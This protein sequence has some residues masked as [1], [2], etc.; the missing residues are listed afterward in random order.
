[1]E[2]TAANLTVEMARKDAVAQWNLELQERMLRGELTQAQALYFVHPE[3]VTRAPAAPG[4]ENS[5]ACILLATGCVCCGRPLVDAKSV[6]CAVGPYCRKR[7]GFNI[8]VSEAAR[9]EANGLVYRLAALL[10]R[11]VEVT[12]E[13]LAG[14]QRLVELGFVV[15]AGKIADRLG[16]LE[17]K[18][19]DGNRLV[20]QAPYSETA[21]AVLRT[22]PGRRWEG[23]AVG[24]SFPVG[25][26][27][28][29]WRA[30]GQAYPGLL[31]VGPTGRISLL[32]E[33]V[34]G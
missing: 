6:E 14:L 20:V 4:Y 16:S 28:A 19:A 17:V 15:L 12:A 11:R 30:L 29:L 3:A 22:V 34:A 32:G 13:V 31:V 18:A 1:M 8:A 2:T 24:N 5:P 10:S 7:H 21:V 33:V 25:S 27:V 9:V 23:K 26:R